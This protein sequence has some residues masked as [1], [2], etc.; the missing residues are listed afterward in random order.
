ML[1]LNESICFT[2]IDAFLSSSNS[3]VNMPRPLTLVHAHSG[4]T[5]SAGCLCLQKA[6]YAYW[7]QQLAQKLT[8][9]MRKL[10]V[11]PGAGGNPTDPS[12]ARSYGFKRAVDLTT[13]KGRGVVPAGAM[14][15]AMQTFAI[16]CTYTCCVS[17]MHAGASDVS[18]CSRSVGSAAAVPPMCTRQVPLIILISMLNVLP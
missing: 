4:F 3:I 16:E 9:A 1:L 11:A 12:V 5:L 8:S 17:C 15:L 6:L 2:Q 7:T 10:E 13:A 18:L 14:T